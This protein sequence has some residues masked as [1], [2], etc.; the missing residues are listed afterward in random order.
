[1]IKKQVLTQVDCC[2][3]SKEQGA[4]SYLGVFL[5]DLVLALL[6]VLEELQVRAELF[7][8]LEL[9]GEPVVRL[10]DLLGQ[11]ADLLRAEDRQQALDLV[12]AALRR[13]HERGAHLLGVELDQPEEGHRRELLELLELR[14]V[15]VEVL[16]E[17]HKCLLVLIAVLPTRVSRDLLDIQ[18]VVLECHVLHRSE[19]L[20]RLIR[21]LERLLHLHLGRVDQVDVVR[22]ILQDVLKRVVLVVA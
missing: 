8:A 6:D 3:R 18:V 21:H 22:V 14:V 20:L 13:R 11:V 2:K 10:V 12:E 9:L 16:L 1:M 19:D 17:V 15:R 7:D 4:S 5:L